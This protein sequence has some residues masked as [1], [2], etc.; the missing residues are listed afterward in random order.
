MH[1][2]GIIPSRYES[3]RFPGKPLVDIDGKPMIQRVYEQCL[4]STRLNDVVI[5]TDDQRIF[6]AVQQFEGKAVMTGS[7][8]E[9]GTSRCLEAA[10]KLAGPLTHVINIQG[11]EPYIAPEQID[12]V[13]ALFQNQEVE[14]A[15]LIKPVESM[16]EYLDP[17]RP[18][19]VTD[20][21]QFALLFSRSP[22]PNRIN[23]NDLSNTFKHIGI[24]GYR[25]D[26]LRK[27]TQLPTCLL[28]TTER[29]EQLRWLYHGYKIK[30]AVTALESHS[31]DTPEDLK[32]LMDWI[33]T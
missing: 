11:D 3:T 28:E 16:E 1:I 23:T 32:N 14:I 33:K 17:N 25:F 27:I 24:Y 29:L 30:T 31:I 20:H 4:K 6:E 8:H 5:A 2:V 15:T 26:V 18:K 12:Q 7:A 22:I 21:E 9:S 19:V 13:C 10:A